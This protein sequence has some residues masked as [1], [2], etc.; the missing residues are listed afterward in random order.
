MLYAARLG[1]HCATG[2]SS[3]EQYGNQA[4]AGFTITHPNLLSQGSIILLLGTS[5]DE[6]GKP[7]QEAIIDVRHQQRRIA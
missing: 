7:F 5:K 3:W 4:Y 1:Y 2:L 6:N